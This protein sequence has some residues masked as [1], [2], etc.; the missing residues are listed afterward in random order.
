MANLPIQ[1]ERAAREAV[2]VTPDDGN[3]LARIT[4][5]IYIGGAGDLQVTMFDGGE[6]TFTALAIG[7][8]HPLQIRRVKATSTT[9]T[10]IIALY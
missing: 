3:D 4:R 5:G 7:V 9:A 1:S 6:V 10:L 2:S 8:V